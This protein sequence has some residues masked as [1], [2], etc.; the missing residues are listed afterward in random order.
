MFA[1]GYPVEWWQSA[2]EIYEAEAAGRRERHFF[3]IVDEEYAQARKQLEGKTMRRADTG[4][5]SQDSSADRIPDSGEG[6]LQDPV[7]SSDLGTPPL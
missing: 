7:T 3:A 2:H 4:N 6:P 1:E 5:F